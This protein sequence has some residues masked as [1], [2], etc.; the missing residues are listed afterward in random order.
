LVLEECPF[1]FGTA[2]LLFQNRD[3]LSDLVAL[4]TV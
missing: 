2:E 1:F 3:R 4:S